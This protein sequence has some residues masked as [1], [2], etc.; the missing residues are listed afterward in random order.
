MA[1]FRNNGLSSTTASSLFLSLVGQKIGLLAAVEAIDDCFVLGAA[2]SFVA[3]ILC[4]FL[5][6]KKREMPV[7]DDAVSAS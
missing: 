3:L 7:H 6:D 1:L 4:L 5:R 2:L